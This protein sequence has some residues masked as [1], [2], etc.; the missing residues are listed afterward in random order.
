MNIVR[1]NFS[2]DHP[3]LWWPNGM[4]EAYL[5]ELQSQLYL[6]DVLID[7]KT[8]R[9]GLRK[10]EV[11]QEADSAGSSFYFKVNGSSLF[12]KGAN[13]IP[14]D[15]FLTRVDDRQYEDLIS[16][17]VQAN[18]NMLRVWGGGVYER[19]IFYELCDKHGLLV[20]QDFMFA[21]NMYPGNPEFLKSVSKEAGQQIKRLRNHPCIALWCGNNEV[22]EGWKNWGWQK[23]MGYTGEDS[24]KLWQ[25]Y[26][27]IF[28]SILPQA[29]SNL[30][31]GAFYWPSSP[32]HGWGHEESM[33]QGDSHYWGVWWGAEP[34]EMYREKVPRFMS[35]YGFQA[36][37]AYATMDSILPEEEQYLYSDALKTH[38]KHPRGF[39]LIELYMQRDFPVPASFEDYI[40]MSQLMQAHGIGMA[41]EAHR[42]A[43]PWCMGSLYWQ[44][45]D[46]WPVVSWSSRDYYGNWKALH[47]RV[48]D[49]F[50]NVKVLARENERMLEVKIINDSIEGVEGKLELWLQ[51]FAGSVCQDTILEY[52][53]NALDQI[54]F[55]FKKDSIMPLRGECEIYLLLVLRNSD[56]RII[57]N[58]RHYFCKPGQLYLNEAE[59]N[60]SIE[61]H[62]EGYKLWLS[63]DQ[64][65]KNLFLNFEGFD[66]KFSD[67]FFDLAPGESKKII[68]QSSQPMDFP[69]KHLKIKSLN[70]FVQGQRVQ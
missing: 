21:C 19:E 45:N 68:F 34:F 30:D 25:A 17:A 70:D 41:I 61:K 3:R 2:L 47:Y 42:F 65:V 28:D 26:Q 15:N 69:E 33:K 60:Y 4:G 64:L 18:M 22:D 35:E 56:D 54:D 43:R 44:L 62:R 49:L 50:K 63:C 37:P 36:F 31:P 39:E 13:Y 32:M 46:C 66:G 29:V 14:Q 52:S 11:V 27:D 55:H 24:L 7:S 38:Q 48:R 12:I 1:V 9:N 5:Y 16:D 8:Q 10:I 58:Y 59:I 20:W 57:D 40:Y 23:Q 53:V 6:D 51:D 67:N